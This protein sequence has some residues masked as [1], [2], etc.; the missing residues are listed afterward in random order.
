M[1]AYLIETERLKKKKLSKKIFS[2]DYFFSS[3]AGIIIIKKYEP[4]RTDHMSA[5]RSEN[6]SCGCIIRS[7][8]GKTAKR[9]SS[10]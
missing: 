6:Y 2:Y 1:T 3:A 4:L 10:S 8:D 7:C 9:V 5:N